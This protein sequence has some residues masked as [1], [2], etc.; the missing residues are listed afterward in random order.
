MFDCN[1]FCVNL[2][3]SNINGTKFSDHEISYANIYLIIV[4]RG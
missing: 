3:Q 1:I 4:I 2:R